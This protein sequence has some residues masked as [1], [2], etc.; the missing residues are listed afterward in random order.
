MDAVLSVMKS[1]NVMGI[2]SW[3]KGFLVVIPTLMPPSAH[4]SR[5][6]RSPGA[7]ARAGTR[8]RGGGLRGSV[9]AHGP[10]GGGLA[11]RHTNVERFGRT[12]GVDGVFW[13]TKHV[14]YTLVWIGLWN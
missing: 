9:V 5:E 12:G 2:C 4:G 7:V 11:W 1:K 13:Y 6:G 14:H 8:S 10:S 3:I